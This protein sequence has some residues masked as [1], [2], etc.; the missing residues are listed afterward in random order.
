VDQA[1]NHTDISVTGPEVVLSAPAVDIISP[2]SDGQY[3]TASGTSDA[4]AIV[5]GVAALVR[6][7]YPTMS[8]A[9]VVH[10]LTATATDKGPPGRDDQYGYGIVNPVAALTADVPPL[11]TSPT[12]SPTHAQPAGSPTANTAAPAQKA[13][14]ALIGILIALL[15]GAAAV[16]VVIARSR[17]RR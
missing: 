10:R 4:T 5:S 17:T 9:E 12:A 6:S 11:P 16:G 8:A 7:K 2:H 13:P 3:L 14:T 1:G 15:V